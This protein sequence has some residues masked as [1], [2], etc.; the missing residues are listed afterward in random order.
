MNKK[1]KTLQ[2]VTW[3]IKQMKSKKKKQRKETEVI[4]AKTDAPYYLEQLGEKETSGRWEKGEG[5]A[6][7]EI[8]KW[9][10]GEGEG[11]KKKGKGERKST[12]GR[13]GK[14]KGIVE[15]KKGVKRRSW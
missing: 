9:G 12:K 4:T 5:L 7:E 13:K 3:D 6:R 10:M 8:G 11:E 14:G 1:G 15:R 2:E